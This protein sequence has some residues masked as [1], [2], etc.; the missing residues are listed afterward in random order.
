MAFANLFTSL[1]AVNEG[2]D[3]PGQPAF[4]HRND[5]ENGKR[6]HGRKRKIQGEQPGPHNKKQ[7]YQFQKTRTYNYKAINYQKQN[8][9]SEHAGFT[10]DVVHN[11]GNKASHNNMGHKGQNYKNKHN[12]NINNQQQQRNK[13]E[14]QRNQHQQKDRQRPPNRG[15]NHQTRPPSRKGGGGSR[16]KNNKQN[17]QVNRTRFMSQEFKDQNAL[18]VD[19]R[20]LCRHF[21]WGRCIKGDDCQLEHIQGYNN[22]IKEVCKFYVQGLC[23]K[24]ESCPYMHKTFP[25]KFFH[26]KGK[27]SQGADCRFSHEPLDDVT[28]QLLDEALKR[29]NDLYELAKKAEQESS[30]Q[31]VN[32]E[33][34][35]I[36][37]ANETPDILIQPLRPNFY[38]S[39]ES[40]AQKEA[41]L[42]QTEEL[43]D[44]TEE[45][46]PPYAT[47]AQS[48]IS[49]SNN[50]NHEEPVCYSV[51][52]V[53]G[54]QLS[55]PFSGLFTT[56]GSQ[57]SSPL[58]VPLTDSTL[59]SANQSEVPYSVDAVLRSCKSLGSSTFGHS[60][61]P[62]AAP[63]ALTVSYTPKTQQL[64]SANYK[65]KDL[66]LVNT[67]NEPN[68]FQ[69]KTF[70]SLSSPQVH[71]GPTSKTCRDHHLTKGNGQLLTDITC[72]GDGKSEVMLK[73]SGKVL[74]SLFSRPPSQTSTPKHP[75]YLEPHLS[76]LTSD[77]EASINYF[78]PSS[79]FT[80]FEGRDAVSADPDASSIKTSDSAHHFAVKNQTEVHQNS[81]NSQS[82][83]KLVAGQHYSSET[84]AECSSK[85][86]H[87]GDLAVGCSK[88][89]KRPFHSLFASPITDSLKPLPDSARPQ[90]FIQSSCPTPQSADCRS[91]D[92]HVKTVV[93]P[94]KLNSAKSFLSLFASP[95]SERTAPPPGMLSQPDYSRT[96]S[97]SESS[98]PVDAVSHLSES[99]QKASKLETPLPCLVRPDDKEISHASKSPNFS[100]SPEKVN[101][102]SSTEHVNTKQQVNLTDSLSPA[103]Q[104]LPNI[105]SHKGSS[106]AATS[107]SVLKTLFLCLSPYQQDGEQQDNIQISVTSES[108]KKDESST[109]C[110]FVEQQQRSKIKGRRRK[111]LKTQDSHKKSTEKTVA[112]WTEHQSSREMPQISLKATD[113]DVAEHQLRISD[114]HNFPFKAVLP[115]TQPH[116]RQ[117]LKQTSE[118]RTWVKGNMT[119]TPLKDLFKT[120]DPAVSHFR[121]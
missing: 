102:E 69:E 111:N 33:E 83:L 68:K 51:E 67:K 88:T 12:H 58:S 24:G 98:Q 84:T 31:P 48:H 121:H 109:G 60:P 55:K 21:L 86:T 10:K 91:K 113:P 89:L 46:I 73:P 9:D 42:C 1:S 64:S 105:S 66:Y 115:M 96:S 22:L 63:T 14:E 100:L 47:A 28:N 49:P 82:D 38:N 97:K 71:S 62:P 30:G 52:A 85:T 3:S 6:N 117:T 110:V 118:E 90:G 70:K 119:V 75:T 18:M 44:V 104:Q 13:T 116:P 107:N 77:S 26:R 80:D 41:L 20:L 114:S 19:G 65:D 7:C 120:L 87:C 25:C 16:N 43:A 59:G 81:K 23:T 72:S 56:P 78:C 54:P 74:H 76:G 11:H 61:I 4:T 8:T 45:T 57:D 15:G 29:E 53:L 27:C 108:E 36:I 112:H 106:V 17:V 50:R 5:S 37:E 95:L 92:I 101:D 40:N 35:E 34:S 103:H 32:T 93:K 79:G 2:V 99:K 39:A 94:D